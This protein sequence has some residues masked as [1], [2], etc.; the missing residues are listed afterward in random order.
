MRAP[1]ATL[2]PARS[3]ASRAR[4]SSSSCRRPRARAE[5]T[6]TVELARSASGRRGAVRA[7]GSVDLGDRG[8]QLLDEPLPAVCVGG[9][10]LRVGALQRRG[11]PLSGVATVGFGRRVLVAIVAASGDRV[12]PVALAAAAQRAV[13]PLARDVLAAED[14]GLPERESLGDVA[15]DR[16]GVLERGP[17]ARSGVQVAGVEPDASGPAARRRR[18]RRAGSTSV[19]VPR[20]PLQTSRARSLRRS[21]TRSPAANPALPICSSAV[22]SAP[23]ARISARARP[24][25]SRTS[26]R[27]RRSSPTGQGRARPTSR[28][29]VAAAPPRRPRPG[30]TRPCSP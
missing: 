13:A 24:L 25:R 26:T 5:P 29:P 15:G 6:R 21:T 7:G 27:R 10:G 30:T 1:A 18:S 8:L 4:A 16:V 3:S 28:P 11:E 22:P 2:P 9:E 14:E 19:T 20:S 17:V 12:E 23:A